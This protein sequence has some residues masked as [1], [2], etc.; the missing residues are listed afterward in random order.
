MILNAI[1]Y[2]LAIYNH[3]VIV[4]LFHSVQQAT[5]TCGQMSLFSKFDG[6]Y[7]QTTAFYPVLPEAFY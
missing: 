4:V 5:F 2:F 3:I 6:Q 1:K 7:T